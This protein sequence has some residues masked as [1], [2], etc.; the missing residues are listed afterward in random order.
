MAGTLYLGRNKVCPAI[1]VGGG[2]NEKYGFSI[3]LFIGNVDNNGVLQEATPMTSELTLYG[4]KDVG[5]EGL[6]RTF[7]SNTSITGN[8]VFQDLENVSGSNG[9]LNVFGYSQITGISFPKLKEVSGERGIER[10]VQNCPNLTSVSFPEL[11][12]V[13]GLYAAFELVSN[14]INVTSVLFPKL[15]TISGE[16]SFCDSFK[17]CS[18]LKTFSF[19]SLEYL[20]DDFALEFIF[21]G[22]TSLEDVYFPALKTTSFSNGSDAFVDMLYKTGTT[23]IHTIHFPSNLESKVQTIPDYPTFGGNADYVVVAFDLPATS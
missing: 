5:N 14:S 13:S 16:S 22:C 8:V 20:T 21:E 17:N 18:K 4:F 3:D 10:V 1:L 15:K 23:T 2:T 11:E 7:M 9:I 6:Y 12:T 19:D